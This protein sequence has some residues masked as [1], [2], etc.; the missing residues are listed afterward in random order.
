[1]ERL[2]CRNEPSEFRYKHGEHEYAIVFTEHPGHTFAVT[3][4][5]DGEPF[6]YRPVFMGARRRG[7][8][9][10]ILEQTLFE[11]RIAA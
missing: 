1:M 7:I 5:Q 6:G 4:Y 2:V 10:N 8:A 9:K 11:K 3:V